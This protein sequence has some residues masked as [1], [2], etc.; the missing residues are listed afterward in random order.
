MRRDAQAEVQ[1]R[2]R[3]LG[4]AEI[5]VQVLVLAKEPVAGRV[6]T[7]LC[8]PLS[9]EGAAAVAEAALLDTLDVVRAVGVRR[10]VLVLDGSYAAQGF[11]V[12]PQVQ[13]PMDVRLAAA[14]DGADPALPTLLIGMDTPQLTVD[15]LRS[16]VESLLGHRAVI[17]LAP[18]GGWWALGLQVPDGSLLQGIAT[19]RD[20]T[21]ARQ[22]QRLERAGLAP[23]ALPELRDVDT[24][25]DARA[26]ALLAPSGRFGRTLAAALHAAEDEQIRADQA[27]GGPAA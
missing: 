9:A 4:Q 1:G 17:G 16:A 11:T 10:R 27:L 7:R 6:K 26:A 12:Q 19:S 23:Y 24:I 8:P 21:G 2:V 20:D 18:D 5:Q 3:A 22:V 14:F 13:G 15:L 25:A